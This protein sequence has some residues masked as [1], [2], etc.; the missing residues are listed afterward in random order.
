ML[1]AAVLEI[2]TMIEKDTFGRFKYSD[3][4][5][6]LVTRVGFEPTLPLHVARV[7]FEPTRP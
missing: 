2:Y 5:E 7:G 1:L 4:A 6:Q 3:S